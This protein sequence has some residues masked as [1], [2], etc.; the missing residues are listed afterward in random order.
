MLGEDLQETKRKV[1][2]HDQNIVSAINVANQ[3][4]NKSTE[5]ASVSQEAVK[6]AL[7]AVL[8]SES[9]VK[10]VSQI[11]RAL[12][13][14]NSVAAQA[15]AI[16]ESAATSAES[17]RKD[18]V[19]T[20][21]NAWKGINDLTK[22]LE[23]IT[24][25]TDEETG[26][27]GVDYL[28][29]QMNDG[30]ATTYDI[31]VVDEK[32]ET[33][34]NTI[35]RNAKELQSLMTVIDKY[36]VGE[37]SQANGLTLEQ[38]QSILEIGMIYVPTEHTE[39]TYHKE[40]YIYEIN[41]ETKTYTRW[42]TPGYLYRWDNISNKEVG[43]GWLTIGNN[44]ANIEENYSD[45]NNMV[46]PDV[47]PWVF[48]ARV[49]PIIDGA[50]EYG[51]WYTDG[52]EIVDKNGNSGVYEPHTL[53]KWEEDHWFAVATLSGNV[54]NRISSQIRQSTN[55][56]ALEVA[57]ARGSAASLTERLTETESEIQSLALWSKGNKEDGEQY[58]LATIKQTADAAGASI[59]QVVESVGKNGKVTAASIV[60]AVNSQ[61]G[62][63]AVDIRADHINFEAGDYT[64]S[65]NH[66]N[67]EGAVTISSLSN[68]VA[69]K[70]NNSICSTEITYALSDSP[71]TAPTLGWST[72][73]P[74]WED[75]KYMWQ[76]T[77]ITYT[78]TSKTPTETTTCI[79][80]AKGQ[81]G[82]DGVGIN[83][84]TITYG[85]SSS[86]DVRPTVWKTEIPDVA[87]GEYLWTCTTI[88]YTD[89][90][91][92]DT[93][94]YSYTK[95]GSQGPQGIQGEK[96]ETG[97]TGAKGDSGTSITVESIQYQAGTSATDAP[98]GNWGDT[99]VD[100]EE[101][102]YLWTKTTFSDGNV[103][104]GVA[105]QGKS[106]ENGETPYVGE[107]GNWWLGNTDTGV[108]AEGQDGAP[109]V[110]VTNVV[111][112][113]ALSTSKE[114][115][116]TPSWTPSFDEILTAYYDSK[117]Q[118]PDAS[119][120][121]WSQEMVTYSS[122]NPTYST[123]TVQSANSMIAS[124]CDQK[125]K[126]K[127]NGGNIATGTITA[128]Q[129]DVNSLF[130]NEEFSVNI[131]NQ[132]DSRNL[133]YNDVIVH[134]GVTVN[135]TIKEADMSGWNIT[136]N[137]AYVGTYISKDIFTI[138]EEY[139][140]SYFFKGTAGKLVNIGGH[141]TG[142]SISKTILDGKE[143]SSSYASYVDGIALT[144]NGGGDQPFKEHNVVLTF[145]FTG[146]D[147]TGLYIQPNRGSNEAI[148]YDLWCIK[149]EKG[150]TATSWTPAPEDLVSESNIITSINAS[151]EGVAISANK[152]AITGTTTFDSLF[153][154]G[155]TTID[156]SKITA[157]SIKA[158]QIDAT[159]LRVDA[160][161]IDGQLTAKQID[162]NA[163]DV[164]LASI[165][166]WDVYNDTIAGSRV[167]LY[168]GD[169]AETSIVNSQTTSPIRMYA[170]AD[171][172]TDEEVYFTEITWEESV[173]DSVSKECS[174]VLEDAK[175][176]LDA[177][178]Q[179][180]GIWYYG[181]TDY[182]VWEYMP[183]EILKLGDSVLSFSGNTITVKVETEGALDIWWGQY[184]YDSYYVGVQVAYTY[185]KDTQPKF[186]VLDDGSLYASAV[187]I[188]GTISASAGTISDWK[189]EGSSLKYKND[190]NRQKG[191]SLF[192][193]EGKISLATVSSSGTE[194]GLTLE[195]DNIQ[196][197]RPIGNTFLQAGTLCLTGVQLN[198][199]ELAQLKT[200]LNFKSASITNSSGTKIGE[201]HQ[202]GH[203]VW[204]KIYK[205]S[206][207]KGA[208]LPTD[209][210][211]P[212]SAIST[213]YAYMQSSSSGVTYPSGTIT[214]NTNRTFS[215]TAGNPR[216]DL[217]MWYVVTNI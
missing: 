1:D 177:Q 76:K 198:S 50:W 49:E 150:H 175:I 188:T 112:Q 97:E 67:L 154:E 195:P 148:T 101:G 145:T 42:F 40:E 196:F 36:S 34:M 46:A 124:W 174:I 107:N 84:M 149:L 89:E 157:G 44:A 131:K 83:S 169:T 151:K 70:L 200:L 28:T 197:S 171:I 213:S 127:I 51:Y 179:G 130:V 38:A 156:G 203:R 117:T 2:I 118:N 25:W 176:I 129:I 191:I 119:Y 4:Y 10:D 142:F 11:N 123:P 35:T 166:G 99:V 122:G 115:I 189:I 32:T 202:L 23:P 108:K 91:R 126:T 14:T 13:S 98:T 138:G 90:S 59:S 26:V 134:T 18:A 80:G 162:V 217:Y 128:N 95:Q 209:I 116:T 82:Q 106:G 3:A 193:A 60:T 155:K 104:Y 194:I 94:T 140:L 21:N 62:E 120:Y 216:E 31:K 86:A 172:V 111:T 15:K 39:T 61:T 214:L 37:Y 79:Q 152:V 141:I 100:V 9:A 167:G 190:P 57:N 204:I 73:A 212:D 77:V 199:S 74:A 81:S 173:A 45:A 168:S 58:N 139:T 207:V 170:G 163:L 24:S 161:N 43:V 63:S 132:I 29:T 160:A 153:T 48:F 78:D 146:I 211:Q 186:M 7:E 105:K 159:E 92:Q 215:D 103:A 210:T 192:G 201:A 8:N 178:I 5:S 135:K 137:Q 180:V 205:N 136:K 208:S 164:N 113:Y 206:Q 65:A 19:D 20:A 147:A 12:E 85:T 72:I 184:D 41:G 54:N 69:G 96:G 47:G 158:D 52:D 71:T 33:A 22:T 27:S 87:D 133:A 185:I 75:D 88:D 121:I 6:K 56:V 109:G 143:I 165:G 187:D 68:D 16:A 30:I 182:E 110:S 181:E 114:T 64:I 55:E 102:Q 125:D 93:V 183:L 66:I 144:E 53:Y 17:M